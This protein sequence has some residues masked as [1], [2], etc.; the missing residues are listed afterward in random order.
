MFS[1][2]KRK[3]TT[4]TATATTD[5]FSSASVSSSPLCGATA[6]MQHV[7]PPSP[8]M[9]RRT[10]SSSRGLPPSPSRLSNTRAEKTHP[11]PTAVRRALAMD[12][13][14]PTKCPSDWPT[15]LWLWT[16]CAAIL[17]SYWITLSRGVAGGDSGELVAEGCHLGTVHPPGYPLLT[18]LH[19]VVIHWL[20]LG[21]SAAWKAN[22]FSACCT[23]VAAGC[24][25]LCVV[26]FGRARHRCYHPHDE[27]L[28][29]P[30][31]TTLVA[32]SAA[33]GL[34]AW[35]PLV[36]QYAVTA[37]VFAL[38]N[39]FMAFLLYATLRFATSWA[40]RDR[41]K[42][43]CTGALVCGLALTNQH[44]AVLFEAPLV[45]Y[46][47]W[48]LRHDM[49]RRPTVVGLELVYYFLIGL[50]PYL[51]LPL[52]ALLFARPGSW[53]QVATWQGFWHHLRRGDYGTFKLYSGSAAV[54]E[55]LN[56]K[57]WVYVH[58]LSLRQG[59]YGVVPV[60]AVV[61][62][63]VVTHI[64]SNYLLPPLYHGQQALLAEA[65]DQQVRR[66]LDAMPANL[67][68][69]R[70]AG[71]GQEGPYALAQ[72]KARLDSAIVIWALQLA[73]LTY[74][75]V[76]HHLSNLPLEGLLYGVMARFWMQPNILVF[77]FCG[78]GMDWMMAIAGAPSRIPVLRRR[79]M[80]STLSVLARALCLGLALLQ[81]QRH[82]ATARQHNHTFFNQ[83]ARSLLAPLPTDA[84]L[85]VSYDMQWT[86]LRYVQVCEGYRSDVTILNLPMMTFK[87]WAS[88]RALYKGKVVFP[89]TYYVAENHP[90][91][92]SGL[93]FTTAA[94]LE[95]NM[96]RTGGV[97][98]AGKLI[99]PPEPQ[100]REKFTTFPVGLTQQFQRRNDPITLKD[101]HARNQ[102][103]WRL[104]QQR[105]GELLALAE[106]RSLHQ[107]SQET[108]ESTI[109]RD[110]LDH[111][112]ESG[113]HL[114]DEAIQLK[115]QYGSS[116]KK[117]GA[118]NKGE[119]PARKKTKMSSTL[120]LHYLLEA[121]WWLELL[122]AHDVQHE[123]HVL[124]NL[125]LAYYHAT[126]GLSVPTSAAEGLLSRVPGQ[127]AFS[128]GKAL[129]MAMRKWWTRT[130][131]SNRP[132][133]NLWAI[134]R[135][136]QTWRTYLAR[137]DAKAH[138][139]F[140]QVQQMHAAVL[141]ALEKAKK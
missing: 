21:E 106:L 97:F 26:L 22:F 65:T 20:P 69:E 48:C 8:T 49:Y 44:T 108:W 25:F 76:F 54:H 23:T 30:T 140:R 14:A 119:T 124:K 4:A 33:A 90:A 130:K 3:K 109:A 91:A 2:H 50:T 9:H 123:A 46:V 52:A 42:W 18:M 39:A 68:N 86:S 141:K 84:V 43:A 51:Y 80:S 112:A 100:L 118:K 47:A 75:Y 24:L 72:A 45:L 15:L 36:W 53:G 122:V 127:S 38:N 104:L 66:A 98:L 79:G 117:G 32:A 28:A 93:V 40:A 41:R 138:P 83:Y 82:Y 1:F 92:Q 89:G 6:A 16:T 37:E 11:V 120:V 88:K 10:R 5:V 17:A 121:A 102:Q 62:V 71:Q 61:G 105:P 114:L 55:S 77:I 35:S 74:L 131:A 136:D 70:R 103:A 101:W 95:A 94:L 29:S 64:T 126:T 81:F 116:R 67:Q 73:F 128:G 34:F 31:P 85:L 133:W 135:F 87:W 107:F 132:P 137:P 7:A 58:D 78:A 59:L 99:H 113:A 115:G 129:Q 134:E 19:F 139:D 111:L 27:E 96:D 125:G 60:V 56:R 12:D 57:L 13:A 110:Y 63:L